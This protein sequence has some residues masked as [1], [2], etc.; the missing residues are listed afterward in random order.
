MTIQNDWKKM[1]GRRAGRAHS[2][3]WDG[4]AVFL[5]HQF[6]RNIGKRFLD[7]GLVLAFSWLIIPLIAI[8][9]LIVSF[10][11]ASPFFRQ[12]RVGRDGHIFR[13]WKLRSMVHNAEGMLD[14]HLQSCA[15]AR[16]EWEQ[17]QKLKRDPRITRFGSFL[18]KSSLDELPQLWNVVL[19]QMSLVG[20]R[21]MMPQQQRIYDGHAYYRLR[22]GLTG[23]WQI[24]ERNET[25]FAARG[26]FDDS[27]E[28]RM[29]VGFDVKI[30]LR[31]IITVYRAT[32]Y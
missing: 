3:S 18:R 20:P 6:Y 17:S 32:G 14:E 2:P 28:R 19:G 13:M 1:A 16:T 31:T 21:P 11:G 8:L 27:Y 29:S 7:V 15:L 24:S 5:P 22:P 25:H 4:E 12:D 10:D 26:R 23:L 30:L 9:A